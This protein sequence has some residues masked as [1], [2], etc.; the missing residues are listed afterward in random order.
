LTNKPKLDSDNGSQSM[1][2]NDLDKEKLSDQTSYNSKN[3]N[4]Y[5]DQSSSKKSI[6]NKI[7]NIKESFKAP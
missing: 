4:Y 7:S 3:Q 6:R 2:M 1:I 5:D